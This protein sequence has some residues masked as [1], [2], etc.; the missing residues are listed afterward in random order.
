MMKLKSIKKN[1]MTLKIIW[2]YK[3]ALLWLQKQNDLSPLNKHWNVEHVVGE[4][5]GV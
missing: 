1:T 2:G 3:G 4:K 5:I